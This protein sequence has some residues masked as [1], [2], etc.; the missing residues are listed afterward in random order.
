MN[1]MNLLGMA[2][3]PGHMFF[4]QALCWVTATPS[5]ILD[6][7][8]MAVLDGIRTNYS[9]EWH[10]SYLPSIFIVII[11]VVIVSCRGYPNIP[12][13]QLDQQKQRKFHRVSQTTCDLPQVQNRKRTG[14]VKGMTVLKGYGLYLSFHQ[15]SSMPLWMSCLENPLPKEEGNGL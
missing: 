12:V 6:G 11:L 13:A 14:K 3:N 1:V 7:A 4:V 15:T 2:R 10:G 8:A 9:T 5:K